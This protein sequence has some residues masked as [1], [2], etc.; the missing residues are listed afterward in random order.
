[1]KY[2]II[3]LLICFMQR[4]SR[5]NATAIDSLSIHQPKLVNIPGL[6]TLKCDFHMH[7]V[8]S[9]G[10]VWPSFRVYEAERDGL[11]V[12]SVTEHVDFEGF[13]DDLKRD[14]NRSYEIAKEAAANTNVLVVKGIEISPRVPPY[15]CNALFIQDANKIPFAYM[16]NSRREFVMNDK[17]EKTA[18]MAPFLEVQ[19][20]GAF[21]SYNHPSYRWWD[22]KSKELFTDFHQELLKNNILAGTEV[23]N[24]GRYNI[25]AHEFAMKYNLTML[26]N[27]DEHY[28]ISHRYRDTH[29]PMTLVF[30]KEK[31][32]ASIKEALMTRNTAVYFDEMLIGRRVQLEPFFK[33][34]VSIYT[35]YRN[36]EGEPII[37]VVFR[38][39][40]DIPFKLKVS[41]DYMVEDFP[42]GRFQLEG[43]GERTLILKAT[44]EAKSPIDLAVTVENILI[45]VKEE[46][47]MV[48]PIIY[49]SL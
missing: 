41:S 14:A 25:I 9:D 17:I 31:T 35:M 48:I 36:R 23:V 12:I 40:T 34:A 18:L 2:S 42:L 38:N 39:N 30:A 5:C 10:H 6:I 37:E 1:M 21:V 3:I 44:W 43:G 19:K 24:T 15:H 45:D 16:K 11:D 27:S 7:T 33:E 4:S 22:K 28:D 49:S 29:R 13:P 46:L 47:N 20:Q 8:F 26:A 32:E